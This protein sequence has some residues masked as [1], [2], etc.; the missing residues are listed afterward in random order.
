M[1]MGGLL[2]RKIGPR[3]STLIGCGIMSLGVFLSYVAIKV[4]FWLLLVTYGAMFG[5]G[6]GIAYVGPIA[7]AMRW[8]PRW[9]GVTAGL[10]V[11]GFGLSALVFDPIQTTFINPHNRRSDKDG[12]FSHDEILDRVPTVF[13]LLGG[14]YVVLQVVGCLMIV[15]PP[16]DE[17]QQSGEDNDSHNPEQ[18]ILSRAN[19]FF[20]H[21]NNPLSDRQQTVGE[22]VRRSSTGSVEL[23]SCSPSPTQVNGDSDASPTDEGSPFIPCDLNEPSWS[24]VK[25]QQLTNDRKSP[26]LEKL[27]TL[28]G[29]ELEASTTS[30]LSM[31]ST[32]SH[33]VV[34][35]LTPLQMLRKLNFYL[36]WFMMLFAGFAVFFTATLYK[37]FGLTFIN[38]DHFL[39]IVGSA[40]SICNCTGRIVWGLVADKVSYKFALVLQSG[41]MCSFL[42]SFY[43]TSAAGM[44]V[45]FI[46]V[47]VI[48]FCIGGIFSVFPTAIA[49]SFG[50]K[51]MSINY[52]LLFSS[53]VI[54]SA[55]AALLFSTLLHLLDWVGTIFMVAGVCLVGFLFTL[56]FRPKRYVILELGI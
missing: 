19:S 29:S 9:K 14:I 7:S 40:S 53:Q 31:Q 1:F 20:R 47:C 36:L 30:T 35:D 56:L 17:S 21:A 37:F 55:M 34:A 8:M 2:E 44:T 42:L 48:F 5:L 22:G 27:K 10:V 11:A 32:G 49:R 24:P 16:G 39:A 23:D 52:G 41:I 46:W 54:S 51:Y 38:D 3:L 18:S 6:L 13:L 12:Y 25:G 26:V 43:A 28:R 33:N 45:F 4:S 15:D 50:S